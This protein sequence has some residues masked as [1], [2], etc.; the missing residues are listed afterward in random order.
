M[1]GISIFTVMC[2]IILNNDWLALRQYPSISVE[3][4]KKNR[5]NNS[6]DSWFM[7]CT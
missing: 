5:K 1:S 3:G 6:H 4:L 2:F 7:V